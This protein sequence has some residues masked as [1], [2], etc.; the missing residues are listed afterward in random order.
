MGIVPWFW[1]PF[2]SVLFL[3]EIVL[4]GRGKSDSLF[5]GGGVGESEA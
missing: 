5:G 1:F 3:R 4:V 2:C